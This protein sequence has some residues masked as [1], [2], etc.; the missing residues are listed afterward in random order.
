MTSLAAFFL[1][2]H[3]KSFD[4]DGDGDLDIAYL[5]KAPP[6]GNPAQ[7]TTGMYYGGVAESVRVYI[8]V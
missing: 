5:L 6:S 8:G 2:S 1:C 7:P 3:L 4:V